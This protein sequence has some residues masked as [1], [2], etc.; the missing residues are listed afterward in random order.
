M[1]LSAFSTELWHYYLSIGI[2][3]MGFGKYAL[4]RS[5]LSKCVAPNETGKIFSALAISIGLFPLISNLIFR[6]LYN[7]TLSYYPGA[8]VI[9]SA[10]LLLVATFINFYLFTQRHRM[11]VT[12]EVPIS[13]IDINV[14]GVSKI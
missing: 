4:V 13:N 12:E 3:C 9:L 7:A 5:M 8:E 14:I 6:Q 11:N 10:C 1:F 2:T